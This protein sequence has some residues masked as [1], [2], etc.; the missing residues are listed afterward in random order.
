[1]EKSLDIEF[2]KAVRMLAEHFP[3]SEEGSRK[4]VLFHDIRVGVYLY[5]RGYA[6]D[7]VLAGVLHDAL[8]FS[9][10]TEQ[11]LREEFGDNVL[12]IV[13]ANSKDRSI[14]DSDERI[15]ELIRRCAAAGQ[16]ALIVK[17]ADTLDSFQHYTKTD[18][19]AELEYCAKTTVAIFKYKPEDFNGA[20]FSEIRKW[21]K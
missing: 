18:N 5:E 12:K 8:E 4:P 2:E 11:M 1:M 15:E 6:R 19:Q 17:A 13:Q 7:I 14:Q 9:D 21:Q 20:V 3:V 16:D 10:I